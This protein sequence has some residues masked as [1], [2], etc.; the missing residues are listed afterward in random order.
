MHL[1]RTPDAAFQNLPGY[2]FPPR[3]IDVGSG[4]ARARMHYVEAGSG[5]KIVLLLHGQPS[6]SYL[7]RNVIR[8]LL[9]ANA[10]LRIFAPD[11]IGFG[12]SDKPSAIADYSY[13]RHMQ[14]LT[15]FVNGLALSNITM[16]V[17]DWG[18]LLGLRLAGQK[19][20]LFAGIVAAN[21]GLPTGH[22]TMPQVWHDFKR[23]CTDAK[24]LPVGRMIAQGCVRPMPD[25]VKKAYA[26]PYPDD[27]YCA[28]VRAFP[29]LIPLTPDD[30]EG[31]INYEALKTLR[32]F[33]RPFITAFSD[34]D[35]ITRGGDTILQ[36]MISGATGQPHMTV[37]EAGHFLQ[38]D[39]PDQVAESMLRAL[40]PG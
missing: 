15:D 10:D 39:A 9:S 31:R 36:R 25:D 33:S 29:G 13:A 2:D 27:S 17:Q 3:Y 18:G 22:Q 32:K 12:R 4:E 40:R 34:S 28:G 30:P 8:H 19:P 14:W 35:P 26:S 38:E 6:W 16:Y 23:F 11:L 5:S 20:D 37:T 7:Y 24:R 21:T 1:L